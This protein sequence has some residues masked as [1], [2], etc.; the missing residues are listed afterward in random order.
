MVAVAAAAGCSQSDGPSLPVACTEGADA[1]ARALARAPGEVRLADGTAISDC[2]RG[3]RSDAEL[4]NLGAVLT[5]VAEDLEARAPEAPPAALQLGYLVGAARRG[6]P[7]DSAV[8]AE[9]V[10]RLE[11]SA[12]ID[13][14]AGAKRALAV[15]LRAGEARG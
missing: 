4:Q 12:A 11:R 10:I 14:P 13:L 5:Q 7:S 8:Q 2:V 1:V 3:A 15:G 9:L 6:A